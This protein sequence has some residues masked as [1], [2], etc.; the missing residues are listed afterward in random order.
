MFVDGIFGRWCYVILFSKGRVVLIYY[1]LR[2]EGDECPVGVFW[3]VE[4][5]KDRGLVIFGFVLAR[6]RLNW[7]SQ[8]D[9]A[10]QVP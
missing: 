10:R 3:I 2:R 9:V 6:I 5:G 4:R 8:G 1:L 7:A